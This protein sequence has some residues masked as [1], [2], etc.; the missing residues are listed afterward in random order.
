[1]TLAEVDLKP[2]EL[3]VSTVRVLEA[4]DPVLDPKNRP[5]LE[6]A[7]EMILGHQSGLQ[8]PFAAVPLA[9]H[10]G[11]ADQN[12]F[13]C[14]FGRDSLLI[15]E[16]L[17]KRHPQLQENVVMALGAVQ[18]I[19]Y[20]D[21]SEEEPGRI[22]HEVREPDDPRGREL[23]EAGN[24]KFPYYGSVDATLIW[25]RTLAT[26]ALRNPLILERE[27]S[28]LSMWKRALAG[29]HWIMNRLETPSG[30]IESNRKNPR[31]IQNQVWK[32]SGD[33]YMHADGTLAIGDSTAS[34]ETVGE[35]YDA[36]L[37]AAKIHQMY[38]TRDWA[39][40]SKELVSKAESLRVKLLDLM[41]L[42]DRFALGTERDSDGVQ[43]PFD[44]QA[45]NQGRLL[46]SR[47]LVGHEFSSY[48][49]AIAEAVTDP[50]L[51]GEAGLRT[52]S[53]SHVSYRPGGYHTGSAW[54]MDGVFTAR[55]LA[56]HGFVRESAL[57]ATRIRQAI[58]SIGGYPEFF[59]GDAPDHGLITMSVANV[60]R[61][62]SN[63][64]N[65]MNR[66]IQPPQIMMGWTI[67]AYAWISDHQS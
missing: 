9:H 48:R 35:T 29:T 15:T 55:G 2:G 34:I 5:P 32:D 58:E 19:V 59:R 33:S 46:D 45:S 6:S 11:I 21:L 42:G 7:I 17:Q 60:I 28:G 43:R 47:I 63:G 44:S 54:P 31:G 18:G 20:D 39:Y 36:L 67:G 13:G 10:A 51:L 40:S 27:V 61:E 30:L 4:N 37:A 64:E 3:I 26:I 56:A 1:V 57:I 62:D 16:L 49:S 25:L 14:L 66:I 41:W 8:V 52:L 12:L 24:W 22:A 23:I 50:A 38:P 65:S 53:T